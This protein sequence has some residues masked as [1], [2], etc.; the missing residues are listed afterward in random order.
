VFWRRWYYFKR[1]EMLMG[2]GEYRNIWEHMMVWLIP[3][4]S[5]IVGEDGSPDSLMRP[6]AAFPVSI[7]SAIRYL[8]A[9]DQAQEEF[10]RG[11]ETEVQEHIER[12]YFLAP[13]HQVER[14]LRL[15]EDT[16]L[17]KSLNRIRS[18]YG[19]PL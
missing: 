6:H 4:K 14:Y 18:A 13:K 12:H 2:N 9:K 10:E 8:K 3:G 7:A 16:Y 5:V 1:E 15:S 19:P 11:W 17:S